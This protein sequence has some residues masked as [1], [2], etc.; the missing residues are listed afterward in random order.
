MEPAVPV[1]RLYQSLHDC[2]LIPLFAR[3]LVLGRYNNYEPI[4]PNPM[5]SLGR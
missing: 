3:L 2:I 1:V 4:R 5:R